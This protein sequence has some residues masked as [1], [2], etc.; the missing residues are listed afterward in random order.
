[1]CACYPSAEQNSSPRGFRMLLYST[2]KDAF[3]EKWDGAFTRRRAL[4]RR[5]RTPAR[6]LRRRPTLPRRARRT[7]V[8]RP[9]RSRSPPP[10]SPRSPPPSGRLGD[11]APPQIP[12]ARPAVSGSEDRVRRSGGANISGRYC[13]VAGEAEAA[14]AARRRVAEHQR[15]GAR[16]R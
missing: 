8:R 12:H 13:R 10:R 3:K 15:V 7:R 4:R 16:W 14:R 11:A 1:M 9:A 2:G 6:H 5:R